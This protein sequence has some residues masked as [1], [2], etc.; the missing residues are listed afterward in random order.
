MVVVVQL[1]PVADDVT[2]SIE[3]YWRLAFTKEPSKNLKDC[4][5]LKRP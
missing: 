5:L 4:I 3:F 2:R 1:A